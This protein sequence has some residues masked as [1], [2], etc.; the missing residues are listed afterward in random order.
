VA[1]GIGAWRSYGSL[2]ES[3]S[4]RGSSARRVESARAARAPDRSAN[5]PRSR[6]SRRGR[7]CHRNCLERPEPS[8]RGCPCDGGEGGGCHRRA[9]LLPQHHCERAGLSASRGNAGSHSSWPVQTMRWISRR[10]ISTWSKCSGFRP[11]VGTNA[12]L[13]PGDRPRPPLRRTSHRP[14]DRRA[15]NRLHQP[16]RRPPH[17]RRGPPARCATATA[18]VKTRRADRANV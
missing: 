14:G 11:D 16:D 18:G 12:E 5:D 17:R 3:R 15:G 10:R 7:R 2:R 6:T 4:K 8:A 9:R 1:G 13:T